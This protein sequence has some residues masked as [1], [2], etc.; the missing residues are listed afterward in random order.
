MRLQ[1]SIHEPAKRETVQWDASSVLSGGEQ[2]LARDPE[3]VAWLTKVHGEQANES[4]PWS[5]FLDRPL[6]RFLNAIG[7]NLEAA[8]KAH[9]DALGSIPVRLRTLEEAIPALR[10][11]TFLKGSPETTAISLRQRY[12][13]QARA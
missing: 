3:I 8:K 1:T 13:T 10:G 12:Q 5:E 4:R 2:L 11:A 6:A 9:A 7:V